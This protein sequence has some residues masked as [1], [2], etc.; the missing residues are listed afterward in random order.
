MSFQLLGLLEVAHQ[1][2]LG[3]LG[4]ELAKAPH[5]SI[6]FPRT[7]PGPGA[8]A[9]DEALDNFGWSLGAAS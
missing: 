3:A 8:V 1:G 4:S 6:V 9:P 7:R 5:A 2:R